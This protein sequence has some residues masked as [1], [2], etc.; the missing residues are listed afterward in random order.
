M[1]LTV[2][3]DNW[4]FKVEFTG[5]VDIARIGGGVAVRKASDDATVIVKDDHEA[6]L[7]RESVVH[8]IERRMRDA[9]HGPPTWCELVG[10]REL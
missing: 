1:T 10:L 9:L 8:K 4:P 3:V 6:W 7:L 2:W 5:T